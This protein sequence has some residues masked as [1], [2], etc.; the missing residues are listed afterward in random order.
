M[1]TIQRP[2]WALS[3]YIG[4]GLLLLFLA[5][6]IMRHFEDVRPEEAVIFVALGATVAY[7]IF[8]AWRAVRRGQ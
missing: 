7:A 1:Q 2:K 6:S 3:Y 8:A 5:V 4:M